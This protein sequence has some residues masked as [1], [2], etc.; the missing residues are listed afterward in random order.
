MVLLKQF[1]DALL[2]A[3]KRDPFY[4]FI[5]LF[6][7]AIGLT[8]AFLI[9]IYIQDELNYDKYF[10]SSERIYRL[11]ANF[12]IKGKDD[13]FAVS[14]FPL[15]PTLMDEYPEIESYT[16]L[17]PADALFFEK[18]SDFFKEDSIYFAD[19]TVT[20]VF[21]LDFIQGDPKKALVE[22]N[23][24]IISSALAQKYFGTKEIV[25]ETIKTNDNQIY[26]VKG[27][28]SNL[29]WNT[30][31]RF[32]GLISSATIAKQIGNERFND[33]S[34]GSF[35][36]ISVYSFVK[37]K[38]NS[39]FQ[40]VLN[41]FPAFYDKYMKE[42]GDQISGGFKL[43]GTPLSKIHYDSSNLQYDQPKGNK[44]YLYILGFVGIFILVI[45]SIN[46]MNLATARSARRAKEVGMRKVSGAGKS[47]LIGQFLGE[48]VLLS[49]VAMI[50]AVVIISVFLPVFNE[51]ASKQFTLFDLL[52]PSIS[53][54]IIG[55]TIFVGILSGLYP[56]FYLSSLD[57]VRILKGA[58]ISDKA[59]A[60]F[61][62]FLVVLQF[63][64]S[65]F[66][67]IASLVV[68]SQ[69]NYMRTKD[70][71]FV[72]ENVVVVSL[73]DSTLRNNI[74]P[75]KEELRKSPLILSSGASSSFPGQNIGKN[76]MRVEGNSGE[77]EE[78]VLN[79]FFVDY[80]YIQMMGIV[81]DTGRIYSKSM[82]TDADKAFVINQKAAKE[83]NWH[84]KALGKRFQN[85]INLDGSAETDGKVIGV[86]KDFNYGSLHNPIEPMVLLI[87]ERS[88]FLG[89][90]SIRIKP[91]S[92]VEALE[93]IKNTR[94]KFNPYFPFE[95][96]FLDQT[97]NEYYKEEFTISKIFKVFTILTLFVAALG[98]LGLSSY[99]TQQKTREIGLRKVLGSSSG[100]IVRMFLKDFGMWVIIANLLT[101]P[102]AWYFMNLWLQNFYFKIS[103]GP[104]FYIIGLIITLFTAMLTVSWQSYKASQLNPAESL[105]Y[106]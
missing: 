98:L 26:M 59:G 61:R 60:A 42:I 30:H 72:K 82:G 36:N 55:I 6:G 67:I 11:E 37:L 100:E 1:Q 3:F 46:Y 43:M 79:N 99:L 24:I 9:Y 20:E 40:S 34:A 74:E 84:E 47:L 4:S 71:G 10:K 97:L 69:L 13:K 86:V 73:R 105:K 57:P 89:S 19:S 101:F 53:L 83:F 2:K 81:I 31:L 78:H 15:A 70:L 77:M 92:E 76:V 14:Q 90:L 16:R 17:F 64:I 106:E 93:W 54:V 62:R 103:M 41:K 91:G 52:S 49:L 75:F 12:N 104:A 21:S 94:E 56:A 85:R 29:P 58:A 27:V 95:Y 80:D 44:S 50:F 51:F 5:N 8:S 102:F 22:P 33:R 25:G 63:A 18:G 45:A 68:S 66:M 28:F 23:T 87:T 39:D 65:V 48:S 96:K 7:L 32:N 35:W 38:P 88:D